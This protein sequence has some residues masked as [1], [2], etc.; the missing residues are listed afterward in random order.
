MIVNTHRFNFDETKARA[1]RIAIND[2]QKFSIEREA[3]GTRGIK[4]PY[5]AWL[6]LCATMT[7]LEDTINHINNMELGKCGDGQAAFD[8]CEFINCAYVVI[9]CIKVVIQ[10][11]DLDMNIIR[12]IESSTDVFGTKYGKEG[13]DSKFFEY[14]RSLCAVH[15][16]CTN[17]QKEYLHESKFHCC[18]FVAWTD[19]GYVR[20]DMY[21]GADLIAHVYT[22]NN[23]H[24]ID[25]EL[26]IKEFERYLG[27]WIDCIPD[28]IEAKNK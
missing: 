27:K 16:L 25:I 19:R 7:R 14:I 18:K 22:T 10:V 6:R 11:F 28:V 13:C 8:F 15:P 26:Y 3:D 12:N 5:N 9:E 24:H 21:N 4:E 1:L 2:R 23:N 17:H 20:S